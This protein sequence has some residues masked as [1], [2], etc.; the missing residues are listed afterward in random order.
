MGELFAEVAHQRVPLLS[1]E[2]IEIDLP[3]E[4]QRLPGGCSRPIVIHHPPPSPPHPPQ[5][6]EAAHSTAEPRCA[7]RPPRPMPFP[8]GDAGPTTECGLHQQEVLC[9]LRLDRDCIAVLQQ[10]DAERVGLDAVEASRQ[11]RPTGLQTVLVQCRPT[12]ARISSMP[13]DVNSACCLSSAPVSPVNAWGIVCLHACPLCR[14]WQVQ[15]FKMAPG[16]HTEEA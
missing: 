14:S 1:V 4:A 12:R 6:A 9:R 8:A 16:M 5:P 7:A 3:V 10:A 11:G 15:A 2:P 13:C